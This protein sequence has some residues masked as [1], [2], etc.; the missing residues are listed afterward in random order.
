M[1]STQPVTAAL[2]GSGLFATNSYLPAL[3]EVPNLHISTV[4]SRSEASASK[5]QAAA[6]ALGGLPHGAATGPAVA[7]GD[8]GLAALLADDAI[9]AVVLVLPITAQPGII[10]RA[11]AAGKH[12]ISEKPLG[13][14]VAEA[15][16]LIDEWEREYRPQGIV[17]RVA[18]NY[19]HEP[20]LHYAAGLLAAP[21]VGDVLYYRL[22][23][24]TMLPDGASYH[25]T[26]WRTVPEYQGGFLLDG[27]VHWAALLRTVLP[28]PPARLIAHKS[29][30][31][32][33]MVPHDTITALA[34]PPRGSEVA[35]H[36]AATTVGGTGDP[37]ALLAAGRSQATGTIILSWAIPDTPRASRPPNE[38]YVV[39]EHATLRLVNHGRSWTVELTPGAGTPAKAAF[40]EG[41]VSGV[42]A[43]LAAFGDAVRAAVDG[44][45]DAQTNFG[46]PEDAL[47][48][49]AFIQAA[50]GSDGREVSI[51][52]VARGE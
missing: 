30:H 33:H 34:L 50:L 11:W 17:W 47:W 49:L 3:R 52:G 20:L 48:D 46:S 9:H 27:G 8:E 15:R 14:D 39:A 4:W 2:L 12:V 26:T 10:R 19:A 31:R 45:H 29:L 42:E 13:R 6:A 21:E 22:H 5:L 28:T 23:F 1:T 16:A 18:E 37:A 35:P 43:E 51:E 24:E 36:G 25:A 7:F 40:K 44:A 41:K 32:A 38:L